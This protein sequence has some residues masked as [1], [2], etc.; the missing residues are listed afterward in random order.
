[1]AQKNIHTT[2]NNTHRDGTL[3]AHINL[4]SLNIPKDEIVKEGLILNLI[5]T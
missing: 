1:M 3:L 2:P 4:M 5:F